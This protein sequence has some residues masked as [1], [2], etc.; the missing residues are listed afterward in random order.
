MTGA[1]FPDSYD[2]DIKKLQLKYREYMDY[3]DILLQEA[4]ESDETFSQRLE[5]FRQNGMAEQ[6][7]YGEKRAN[8]VEHSNETARRLFG[9]TGGTLSLIHI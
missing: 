6:P 3:D 5:E 7:D 1:D 8:I 9:H 2:P 4:G